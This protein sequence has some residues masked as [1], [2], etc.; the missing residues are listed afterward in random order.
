MLLLRLDDP[1]DSWIRL[2]L[3]GNITLANLGRADKKQTLKVLD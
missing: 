1:N 3:Y 2:Q